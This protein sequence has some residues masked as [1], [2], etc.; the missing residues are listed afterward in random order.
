M[1]KVILLICVM[2]LGFTAQAQGKAKKERMSKEDRHAK[3]I[4]KLGLSK[5]Q[6]TQWLVVHEKY[7][8]QRKEAKK[9][10]EAMSAELKA[11]LTEEQRAKFDEMR[12]AHKEKR[13][14]EKR[15]DRKGRG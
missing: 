9:G 10:R 7:G 6:A 8:E 5:E 11:L 2:A 4:E 15:G 3:V 13:K 1:K 14:G 12:E